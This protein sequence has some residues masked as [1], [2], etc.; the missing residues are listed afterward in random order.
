[1]RK[2]WL[3]L[4][5]A[6]VLLVIPVGQASVQGKGGRYINFRAIQHDDNTLTVDG[7]LGDPV[8]TGEEVTVELSTGEFTI[9]QGRKVYVD[10][11]LSEI[12]GTVNK[13]GYFRLRTPPVKSEQ[14]KDNRLSI[15]VKDKYGNKPARTYDL[16]IELKSDNPALFTRNDSYAR[17]MDKTQLAVSTE[18]A[19]KMGEKA[20]K[21]AKR[22]A[23]GNS[24]S[25]FLDSKG[26]LW[27]WGDV[28]GMFDKSVPDDLYV[29]WR[30][31]KVISTIPDVIQIDATGMCGA[32]LT[33]QGV[34]WQWNPLNIDRAPVRIGKMSGVREIAVDKFGDGLILKQ[35]GTL[36]RWTVNSSVHKVNGEYPPPVI[37]IKKIPGLSGIT[38]IKISNPN[39]YRPLYLALQN[40]GKVWAW[41]DLSNIGSSSRVDKPQQLK[42]FPP[43]RQIAT[44][45]NY[46]LLVSNDA[47][48]WSYVSKEDR[49]G[50][51][52]A[53][54]EIG[55]AAVFNNS[56]YVLAD[57]GNYHEWTEKSRRFSFEPVSIMTGMQAVV[58]GE[59]GFSS[60]DH[61][62][63]VNA[64]G[65]L[66]SWG[67]N[68]HGQL[69]VSAA[70]PVPSSPVMIS[71]V[72]NAV[73]VTTS[74]KHVL[75]L[76]RAGS[77]YGWGSNESK[78]IDSSGR[79]EV[80]SPTHIIMTQG[81][82]KLAAGEGFSL[83][84]DQKGTLYGWGNLKQFG[85]ES[86]GAPK[87]ITV[88]P[89][90]IKDI[91]V[92]ES[93][94]A[95]LGVSGQVYLI[96]KVTNIAGSKTSDTKQS[97]VRIVG[98][99]S[100]ATSIA[101]G[102]QYGYALRKDGTVSYW[103][104]TAVGDPIS[105]KQ[106]NGLRNIT[107]LAA[108]R[109]NGDYLLALDKGGDVWA[110]GDN[111]ARQ[112]GMKV[113][114]KLTVPTNVTNEPTRITD[115]EYTS[116]GKKLKYRSI[117]ASRNGA[118]LLTSS[119]EM[120]VMGFNSYALKAEKLYLNVAYAEAH[121]SNMYW[122]IGGKLYVKG[123]SNDSG[124]MGTG[125]K[126]FIH[127][128]LPVTTSTGIKLKAA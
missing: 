36:Y 76:D 12:K 17:S 9:V 113:K 61:I 56:P 3:S 23:T 70:V 66:V 119:N 52:A 77:I 35:D 22:L 99:I 105:A 24:V 115:S 103:K 44:Y 116:V 11:K 80:L 125:T 26:K 46:P 49:S 73:S 86:A 84:L 128:P 109:A 10:T 60:P 29:T 110:W 13:N 118:L 59:S 94:V 19:R 33:K 100:D 111:T 7:V 25:F 53:L 34:I 38:S 79:V 1:M 62:L 41:G 85:I 126:A 45:S 102:S 18:T 81:V 120:L 92:F 14:L 63:A 122:I 96:D 98:Q 5:L 64:E 97:S 4:L 40:N 75:A 50:V 93:N 117:T 72:S 21:L 15:E 101:M 51:E 91:S 83:Y 106:L 2:G 42:E 112:L 16:P 90:N 32:L 30:Q 47:E 8:V 87:Q 114:S 6:A 43:I 121:D 55:I 20:E 108:A 28:P 27:G 57:N 88:I 127:N 67:N 69:G 48:L 123:S 107:T 95:V 68:H 104:K 71:K 82:K 37:T 65:H 124:Q 74:S 39:L 54:V 31:P 78:Q 58:R 89:E